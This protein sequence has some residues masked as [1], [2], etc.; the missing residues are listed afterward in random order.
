MSIAAPVGICAS[1][2]VGGSRSDD[3]QQGQQHGAR[4]RGADGSGGGSGG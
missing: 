1:E 3:E 4:V 2:Q